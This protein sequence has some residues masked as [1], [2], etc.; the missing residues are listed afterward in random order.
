VRR[1]SSEALERGKEQG[2]EPLA[3]Q[4]EPN[5]L[6]FLCP[7]SSSSSSSSYMMYPMTT[8]LYDVSSPQMRACDDP[9]SLVLTADH[10]TTLPHA[11]RCQ[12]RRFRT[13]LPVDIP[14]L[15]ANISTAQLSCSL[16]RKRS[17]RGTMTINYD[18]PFVLQTS[19]LYLPL[20]LGRCNLP[21]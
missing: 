7:S 19:R 15:A 17:S 5:L 10:E 13:S 6:P 1:S 8:S 11:T 2:T 3:V 21:L 14:S 9:C 12:Q 16:K 4:S 18:A 20:Y